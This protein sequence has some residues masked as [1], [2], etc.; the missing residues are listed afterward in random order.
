M[1]KL[2]IVTLIS[3]LFALPLFAQDQGCRYSVH[4]IQGQKMC[5]RMK[6]ITPGGDPSPVPCRNIK[7]LGECGIFV[8]DN[9]AG[10]KFTFNHLG[11]RYLRTFLA[12]TDFSGTTVK[13]F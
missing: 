4:P 11:S 6:S 3:I 5:W 8:D 2:T 10:T 9:L 12:D 13:A 7:F 1:K